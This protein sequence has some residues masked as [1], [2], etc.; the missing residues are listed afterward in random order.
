MPHAVF[1]YRD[2]MAL[3]DAMVAL[4]RAA[5]QE[6]ATIIVIATEPHRTQVHARFQSLTQ[7][8]IEAT[9]LY[10]DA[11]DLLSTFMV[12]GLPDRT[13]FISA[14]TPFVEWATLRGPIRIFGEMVGLLW[15]QGNTTGALRLEEL[16]TEL[17]ARYTFSRVCN[18]PLS[19]FSDQHHENYHQVCHIHTRVLH[20]GQ[21]PLI[22]PRL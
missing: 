10:I 11:V 15:T 6:R 2:D 14:L 1:F 9:V 8:E 13:R 16:W 22:T 7:S 21:A 3:I 12:N 18:Y 20:A 5:Y 17:A 19:G 4:I